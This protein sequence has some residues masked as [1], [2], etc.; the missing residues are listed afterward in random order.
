MLAGGEEQQRFQ[1]E[2]EA[3]ALLDHPH[4]VPIYEVSEHEGRQFFSM[5]LVSG[6]SLEKRLT[7]YTANPKSAARL[8]KTAAEAVHHAHQRDFAP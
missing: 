8:V 7:D 2:A 1:N 6:P 3:V 4:I 5:K